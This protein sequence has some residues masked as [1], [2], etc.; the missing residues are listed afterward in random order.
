MAT[1]DRERVQQK[2]DFIARQVSELQE[3]M[4]TKSAGEILGDP[5]LVKGGKYSLQVAIEAM[6]DVAYHISARGF[7]HAPPGCQ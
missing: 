1:I 4:T 6:I 5:W 2:L 3:L 7:G